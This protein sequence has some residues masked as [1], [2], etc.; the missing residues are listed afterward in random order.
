MSSS[1]AL[2]GRSSGQKNGRD[3]A[4]APEQVLGKAYDAR[5]MQ[6]L[7]Q[8]VKPHWRL[9][10]LS[11]ALIPVVTALKLV[12]PLLLKVAIDQ[13]IGYTDGDTLGRLSGAGT[14]AIGP[15]SISI[16]GLFSV[17]L[18]YMV[19]VAVWALSQYAQLYSM[20]LL[21]Q[22]SMHDL[23]LT[24]YNHV[25]GQRSGFFDR[26]PV[27]RLLT[28]MTN[29]I[30]SINEMFAS[31]VVTLV[32][33]I[34]Q[35]FGIVVAMLL[36]DAELTL[37]TFVVLPLLVAVVEYARRLMRSS[38]RA[39]RVK[40]A[41]LNSF[42]QE[43]LSGIKVVQLFARERSAMAEYNTINAAHRDAY[44]K[45]I[46]ADA[47]MYAFVEAISVVSIALIAWYASGYMDEDAATIGLVVAFIEYVRLFFIPVRDFSAK[48]TVMQS[49]LAASERIM[50][51][52]DQNEPDAATVEATRSDRSP[53]P[54]ADCAVDTSQDSLLGDSGAESSAA[55][56]SAADPSCGAS[57]PAE[58]SAVSFCGVRFAYR[59]NE[60]VLRSVNIDIARGQTVAVVGATG[61]GKS[62]LIKVLA[63][64]YEVDR[65]DIRL[66]G[67][68]IRDLPAREIRRRIT[69]VSQDV[70]L[71]AGTVGDNVRL[72]RPDADDDAIREALDRV[73]ASRILA[74][75]LARQ[76]LAGENGA[77]GGEIAPD[78]AEKPDRGDSEGSREIADTD[79]IM[80]IEI[81][82][83]GSNFSAGERQLI[84][85]ARALVRD[86]EILVLDEATAHVDPEAEALIEQGVAE[87]MRGRT[88]LVIAHRL[89]TIRNSDLIVVM[90]R[91]RI[92]ERGSHGE[93]VAKGGVYARLERTF[94]RA[95]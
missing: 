74:R 45:S 61:S 13:Y 73:G 18:F 75:R 4:M 8:F 54:A 92:V 90:A 58:N 15:L 12:Q 34:V 29:D 19:L 44:F 80:A 94:S 5:L 77:Q 39:I 46:R 57:G 25:L 21:G 20:Q 41:A 3:S 30:E 56:A 76:K 59:K 33:D 70:F 50:A 65:G 52:L 63:R 89:S 86:P 32:A 40:L 82:E 72:G 67:V 23:R 22:R 85:F 1:T 95:D 26:M 36:L 87:L 68:D 60:P 9:L 88:T 14:I 53:R 16:E 10:L 27:G 81:A 6:R 64:L 93:L 55:D 31:G 35:L 91:G 71:F 79:E 42:A 66:S 38:F 49:A 48:Y 17:V 28:R 78:K 43:H 7:W 2:A 37:I 62:T 11:L 83:R 47:S 24:T 51:L 84:A 69:V